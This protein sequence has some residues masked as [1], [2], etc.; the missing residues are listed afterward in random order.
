MKSRRSW[1]AVV[2]IVAIA[3]VCIGVLVWV[4]L[5]GGLGRGATQFVAITIGV[6]VVLAA[7]VVT[8]RLKG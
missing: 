4:L 3:V 1:T 2:W 8:E 7:L 6:T 5:T